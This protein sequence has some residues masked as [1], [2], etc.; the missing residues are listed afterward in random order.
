MRPIG[1]EP[2][3]AQLARVIDVAPLLRMEAAVLE[4]LRDLMEAPA[5]RQLTQKRQIGGP[6][7]PDEC[8]LRED[9]APDQPEDRAL[10]MVRDD[11]VI[12][13][14]RMRAKQR[15]ISRSRSSTSTQRS[16]N[17][18]ARGSSCPFHLKYSPLASWNTRL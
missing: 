12:E 16:R 1:V 8:G 4:G 11:R 6:V 2:D 15:T 3:L 18:G 14:A 10:R 13:A 7:A 5:E 9:A 17:V